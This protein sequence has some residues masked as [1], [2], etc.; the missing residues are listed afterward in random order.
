MGLQLQFLNLVVGKFWQ[1]RIAGVDLERAAFC[2]LNG[3]GNRFRQV[4]KQRDH[5]LLAF[6]IML[7]GQTTAR[8]VLI[9]IGTVGDANQRVVR[10]IN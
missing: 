10:L 5:L 7:R 8:F 4:R 1:D 3:V 2:N 9:D 6:E